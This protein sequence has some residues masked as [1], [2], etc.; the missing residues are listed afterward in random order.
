MKVK[1]NNFCL[2]KFTLS[3]IL[4]GILT[5][6]NSVL[7]IFPIFYCYYIIYKDI[8]PLYFEKCK[9]KW[10]VNIFLVYNLILVLRCIFIDE[11]DGVLGNWAMSM[12]G[13]LQVGIP[14][15]VM[16]FLIALP[17]LENNNFIDKFVKLN[18]YLI[19]VYIA[20]SILSLCG[21]NWLCTNPILAS[22]V[23]LSILYFLKIKRIQVILVTVLILVRDLITDERSLF[24]S[25]LLTMS[26]AI[27][28]SHIKLINKLPIKIF[29]Y[30]GVGFTIWLLAFNLYYKDDFFSWLVDQYGNN[31]MVGDN[32]RSFLFIEL[33][34]DF[35]QTNAWVFGKGILGTY[36]SPE[37]LRASKAGT[38]AD[39]INR[40]ITECGWL[41]LILK[42]GIINAVL[43]GATQ[44]YI[45]RTA[46]KHKERIYKIFVII[47]LVH[48][49]LMF[50]SFSIYF[51][52]QNVF[53]WIIAGCCLVPPSSLSNK[54]RYKID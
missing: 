41:L 44:V 11:N 45:I 53:Y 26:A 1:Y 21:I 33:I 18:K 31:Q 16:P 34:N 6:I 7:K 52:L 32:T 19:F 4:A 49:V 46:L 47:L 51:D 30:I 38:T 17:F 50:V 23:C 54:D 25:L 36:F 14:V 27:L 48:F 29:A 22:S 3:V 15:L 12:L 10:I 9:N 2:I 37:M 5:D 20:F 24:L 8:I 42:G 13:N 35:D 28:Y 43:Y 40:L 39:S